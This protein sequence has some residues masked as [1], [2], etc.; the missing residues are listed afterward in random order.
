MKRLMFTLVLC[1]GLLGCGDKTVRPDT[2]VVSVT[3]PV[4]QEPPK[5]ETIEEPYLPISGLTLRSSDEEVVKAYAASIQ[6]LKSY[7]D[8]LKEACSPFV[9]KPKEETK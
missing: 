7:S 2:Q 4:H 5:A 9:A 3:V 8:M 6:I 1:M